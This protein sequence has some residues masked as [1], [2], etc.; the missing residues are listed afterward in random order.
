M[1]NKEIEKIV[2]IDRVILEKISLICIYATFIIAILNII[3][4]NLT[5]N[6]IGLIYIVVSFSIMMLTYSTSNII[7]SQYFKFFSITFFISAIANIIKLVPT[8]IIQNSFEGNMQFI[9]FFSDILIA[10]LLTYTPY[11]VRNS[12]MKGIKIKYISLIVIT[13]IACF[14]LSIT[15]SNRH[16]F[17]II[18]NCIAIIVFIYAVISFN[19]FNI[20][21]GAN[22]NYFKI[23]SY[24][25]LVAFIFNT[26]QMILF[27]GMVLNPAY[28]LIKLASQIIFYGC[29]LQKLLNNSY[30]ILF[31]DL[32]ERNNELNLLNKVILS[33]NLELETSKNRVFKREDMFKNL[34]K[35]LPIPMLMINLSNGRIIY[36][37]SAFLNFFKDKNLK[38]VINKK[39]TDLVSFNEEVFSKNGTSIDFSSIYE[40][41]LGKGDLK[42]YLVF[43]FIQLS[44]D[45]SQCLVQIKDRTEVVKIEEIKRNL[46]QKKIEDK[47]RGDFLSNI[48]HDIKTPINVIYSA[49][50]LEKLLI[51]KN[52]TDEVKKYNQLSKDNC[53]SLIRLTNNLIDS[54]K[55][56]SH[57]L[58][59]NM[60]LC[61]IVEVIED[62]TMNLVEYARA[63]DVHLIFDTFEEEIY[64]F[65]DREFVERIILNLISNALK[66]SNREGAILVSISLID[67]EV[68][69]RVVDNGIGMEEE[70]M[71]KACD[72][73]E[74]GKNSNENSNVGNGIGL[75]VVKNLTELQGGKI[76]IDSKLN[77]GTTVTLTFKKGK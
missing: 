74:R 41:T 19:D 12:H 61:N 72:R 64:V 46:E 70:F 38:K 58:K 8:D 22:I 28:E 11:F 49:T 39:L 32:F 35:N 75:Y 27:K 2:Y 59:P 44:A 62:Q 55:L 71:N 66:F 40:A 13:L 65:M 67:E 15:I 51:E 54:S 53:L 43:Q 20:K 4:P 26:I 16:L 30:D 52:N 3:I 24:I 10:L 47:I 23:Y 42:Y 50:Q 31:N 21:K 1:Y 14:T 34:F 29:I 73:Y 5:R 6:I 45:D 25:I 77:V 63:K 7:K 57:Y 68:K 17:N 36:A 33:K 18:G 76:T 48:S 9:Y 69:I 60:E 56:T 37:N